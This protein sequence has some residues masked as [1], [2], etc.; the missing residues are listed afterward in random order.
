MNVTMDCNKCKTPM[1]FEATV[2]L[3]STNGGEVMITWCPSCGTS[4]RVQWITPHARIS[5]K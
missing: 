1:Q 5:P 4:G 2:K 3:D